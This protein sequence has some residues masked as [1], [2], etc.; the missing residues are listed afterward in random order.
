MIYNSLLTVSKLFMWWSQSFILLSKLNLIKK[1]GDIYIYIY[2]AFSQKKN[3]PRQVLRWQSYDLI[4]TQ[5]CDKNRHSLSVHLKVGDFQ[6][7]LKTKDFMLMFIN[8][9]GWVRNKLLCCL[10]RLR[11]QH[12]RE[13]DISNTSHPLTK[14]PDWC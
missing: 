1:W 11:L 4:W 7:H 6:F 14:Q 3:R 12:I 2:I 10:W 5:S 9:G 8:V 13:G